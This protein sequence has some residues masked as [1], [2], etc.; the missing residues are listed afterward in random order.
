MVFKLGW[1]TTI[2]INV[3]FK[4]LVKQIEGNNIFKEMDKD[5][6]HECKQKA[7][8]TISILDQ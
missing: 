2:Y 7:E 8:V 4:K 5:T 6:P 3:V 1:E